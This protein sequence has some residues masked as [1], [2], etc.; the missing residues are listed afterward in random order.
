MKWKHGLIII[1]IVG[2][3]GWFCAA[4]YMKAIYCVTIIILLDLGEFE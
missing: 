4:Q 1:N 3:V 2:A